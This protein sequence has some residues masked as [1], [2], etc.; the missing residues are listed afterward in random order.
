MISNVTSIRRWIRVGLMP[1]VA[2]G[3]AR[4]VRRGDVTALARVG[5]PQ[6]NAASREEER[7]GARHA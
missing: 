1:S 3:R 7:I 2:L 5:L 4:R 6:R